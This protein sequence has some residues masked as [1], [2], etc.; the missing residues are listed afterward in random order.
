MINVDL[1]R[2]TYCGGCVR[3]CPVDALALG[4]TRLLVDDAGIDMHW[5][6]LS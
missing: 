6:R 5:R 1:Y 3:V 2:C 4:E